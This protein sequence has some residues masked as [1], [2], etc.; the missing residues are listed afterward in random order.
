[1]ISSIV[2]WYAEM[3]FHL[4]T[5]RP[6]QNGRH[7]ADDMFKCI[8]WM[9]MFEFRLKFHWSLFLR[10]QLTIIQHCFREWLGAAQATSHY[11]KQWWLVHW[12]IYASLGLNELS[13]IPHMNNRT[14]PNSKVKRFRGKTLHVKIPNRISKI[15]CL[16]R[17]FLHLIS[18]L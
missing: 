2:Q 12:R 6:G 1:M 4:N 11:L 8:F 3:E 16:K 7:F 18:C 15:Y 5:L 9:K 14:E 17:A 10:V 13:Q